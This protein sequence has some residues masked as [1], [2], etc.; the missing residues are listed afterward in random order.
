MVSNSPPVV[1]HLA[2]EPE[3]VSHWNPR[4]GARGHVGCGQGL[5]SRVLPLVEE[6]LAC[7]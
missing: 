5:D 7:P 4:A 2:I 6:R 1:T 3:S